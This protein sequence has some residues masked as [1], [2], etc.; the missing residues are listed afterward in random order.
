M[1]TVPPF[2]GMALPV[3]VPALQTVTLVNQSADLFPFPSDGTVTVTPG[4]VA[5]VVS[6]LNW[7]GSVATFPA[8]A[9]GRR[10][11][12]H[13]SA[14]VSAGTAVVEL[15]DS[16]WTRLA[17]V[18]VTTDP[19]PF[20]LSAPVPSDSVV[21]V[22]LAA[23]TAGETLSVTGMAIQ[24]V[25]PLRRL[26]NQTFTAD[27]LPFTT[28]LPSVTA[29]V[30]DQSLSLS[31]VYQPWTGVQASFTVP[32]NSRVALQAWGWTDADNQRFV[33]VTDG[34]VMTAFLADGS[35]ARTL[36][37]QT[38]VCTTGQL[39]ITLGTAYP[40]LTSHFDRLILDQLPTV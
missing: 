38:F 29:S 32:A 37:E 13:G 21:R 7:Y 8:L 17:V 16:A 6:T 26:V 31:S 10:I 2:V 40:G 9:P 36:I 33:R 18:N 20:L 19:V 4:T 28:L 22:R 35:T 11:T 15:L 23:S 39:G 3:P 5:T 34:G 24:L 1:L 25:S 30:V 12:V 14:S 27:A